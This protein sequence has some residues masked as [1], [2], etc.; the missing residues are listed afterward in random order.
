MESRTWMYTLLEVPKEL[1]RQMKIEAARCELT[2][3]DVCL[4]AFEVY[5]EGSAL[6]IRPCPPALREALR[7]LAEAEGLPLYAYLIGILEQHV[8]RT[9]P[10]DRTL[11]EVTSD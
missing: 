4:Q 8:V 1:H 10:R 11:A 5:L 7:A 2:L 9:R 3:K 6:N